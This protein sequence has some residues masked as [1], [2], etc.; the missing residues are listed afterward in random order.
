MSQAEV[1]TAGIFDLSP[2]GTITWANSKY[3]EIT[4][5]SENPAHP[6]T[7]FLVDCLVEADAQEAWN[8]FNQCRVDH[9]GTTAD[10]RIKKTWKPPESNDHEPRWVL[11]SYEPHIND[12]E[13]LS[14]LGCITDITHL[15]WAEQLQK[16]TAEKAV[17]AR[18][19]QE[20]FIDLTS[21]ELRNVRLIT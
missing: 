4:N 3:Y 19:H 10:L 8:A 11:V 14:V 6:G 9:M 20:R 12:G 21:H 1:A 15:K 5:P 13:F 17:A 16:S 7:S 18:L 2:N